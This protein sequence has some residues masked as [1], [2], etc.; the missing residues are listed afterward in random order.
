MLYH[1]LLRDIAEISFYS[2]SIFA[3]CKWLKIDKTKN[4]LSYFL[5][6]STL[7]I[8]SWIMELPTLAPFLLAYAPIALLLFIVL[9]EKALQRNLVALCTISPSDNISHDWVDT[10]ISSC[11]MMINANKSITIVIEYKD[12][13]DQFL[14]VPFLI[15]ADSN[16][17]VF[18][19]LLSSTSYDEQKMVWINAGGKIRSFNA[20]WILNQENSSQSSYSLNTSI[21]NLKENDIKSD[22]IFYTLQSD[23]L[24]LMAH[25][26]Q[27]SFSLIINGKE[28]KNITAHQIHAMIKR[29]FSLIS[30]PQKP[31]GAYR[32]N[33][34]AEK[35]I[36]G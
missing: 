22:M 20:S 19:I 13:L 16:K 31:K 23:A 28:T 33:N 25:P 27:R 12:A 36:S 8:S 4:M 29:Q 7:T 14:E 3:F 15:N 30:L 26:I 32:E 17:N 2:L 9:H 35:S 11:L 24:I 10:I 21:N 1:L 6:Y 18:D 34:A 5:A